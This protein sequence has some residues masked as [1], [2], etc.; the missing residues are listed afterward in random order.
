MRVH[1]D[2]E[3]AAR[4]PKDRRP[5]TRGHPHRQR[6]LCR[7]R[8]NLDIL[9]PEILSRV[10]QPLLAPRP[11]HDLHGFPESRRTFF[12]RHPER[13]E[14]PARKPA[15]G[16]PVHPPARQHVQKSHFLGKPK[17]M[18]ERGQRHRGADPQP[19]GPSRGK[20]PHH[21]DRRTH[22]EA[23]EMMLCQPNRVIAGS[24]HD[25]D[26]LNRP[27]IHRGQIDPPLRP[28]EELQDAELHRSATPTRGSN[29]ARPAAGAIPLLRPPAA[30]E[31]P[32]SH[33]GSSNTHRPASQAPRSPGCAG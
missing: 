31:V 9:E 33:A 8:Q 10:V 18:V 22:A 26:A 6:S 16:T 20:G 27:I 5:G 12:R 28:T 11:Q 23:G 29:D 25:L 13:G 3:A 7:L 19:P 24:I 21:V 1:Q 4:R 17:R 14:L 15:A 30:P 2:G 32:L